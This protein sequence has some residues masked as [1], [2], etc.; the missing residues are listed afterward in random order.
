MFSCN[1]YNLDLILCF[2]YLS[3]LSFCLYPTMSE[4]TAIATIMESL[5]FTWGSAGYMTRAC[6]VDSLDEVKWMDGED[7]VKNTIKR[8]NRP[9]G[10]LT[11]GY[12]IYT[13]TTPN[14]GLQISLR[15]ENN[16][17]L[18]VYFLQHM[19][20]VHRVPTA[21]SI[22]LEVVRGYREK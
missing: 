10:T 13:V 5:G 15:A 3:N 9:G 1:P 17:K 12:G 16:L 4:V 11:V 2:V 20:R 7:D 18:C 6:N 19:E 22:T 8:L 21:A 14:V